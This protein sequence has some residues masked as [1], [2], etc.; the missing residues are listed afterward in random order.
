MKKKKKKDKNEQDEDEG[1]SVSARQFGQG[2]VMDTVVRIPKDARIL[3]KPGKERA[4]SH[5][6]VLKSPDLTLKYKIPFEWADVLTGKD[7]DDNG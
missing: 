7:G 5:L 4:L 1:S 2:V 3:G 6:F